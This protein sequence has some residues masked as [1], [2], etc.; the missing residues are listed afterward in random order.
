MKDST[1]ADFS[2]AIN[3]RVGVRGVTNDKLCAGYVGTQLLV[4]QAMRSSLK[5]FLV[6]SLQ[7]PKG[8]N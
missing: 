4:E 3:G 1:S 8:H 2:I 7:L 5:G 6:C